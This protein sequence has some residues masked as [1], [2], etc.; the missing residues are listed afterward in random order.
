MTED[1]KAARAVFFDTIAAN[2]VNPRMTDKGF[3]EFVRE[4]MTHSSFGLMERLRKKI[5]I[6]PAI[7]NEQ[8]YD[9]QFAEIA[10]WSKLVNE[11]LEILDNRTKRL[12]RDA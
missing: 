3:R 6:K 11:K 1:E 5:A 4:N 7:P 9:A 2:T 12:P 10:T 8:D